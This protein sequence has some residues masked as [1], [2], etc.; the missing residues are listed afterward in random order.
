MGE[1]TQRRAAI[2]ICLICLCYTNAEIAWSAPS[3]EPQSAAR[4]KMPVAIDWSGVPDELIQRCRL[5]GLEDLLL[6]VLIQGGYAAVAEPGPDGFLLLLQPQPGG[7]VVA[8]RWHGEQVRLAVPI[9]AVCESTI[10]V[11]ILHAARQA[12]S[13]LAV[14]REA[15]LAPPRQVV[16]ATTTAGVDSTPSELVAPP[17][18][19]S[20]ALGAGAVV[21]SS[22][23]LPALRGLAW[24]SWVHGTQI[25]AAVEVTAVRSRGMWVA[26]AMA[27]ARVARAAGPWLGVVA[28]CGLE[29]GL[30]GHLNYFDRN[31]R[32]A[33]L[34]A[35]VGLPLE[36]VHPASHLGI[37]VL[38]FFRLT[39]VQ[40]RVD[41]RTAYQAGYFGGEVGLI[42]WSG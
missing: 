33:Y 8:G 34:T 5:A 26:E 35:R 29:A 19:W 20:G 3:P 42:Y 21:G 18:A 6:Q 38:P 25:G 2:A 13:A 27:A 37:F 40:A 41:S 4:P 11:E 24:R 22:P 32:G 15:V 30:L 14:K 28:T 9:S 31:Q 12:L 39:P 1:W 17:N 23:I 7:L 16:P 36:L 10:A